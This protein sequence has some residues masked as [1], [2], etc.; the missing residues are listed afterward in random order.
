MSSPSL[1][2]KARRLVLGRHRWVSHW[3]ELTLKGHLCPFSSC[4]LVWTSISTNIHVTISFSCRLTSNKR[5]QRINKNTLLESVGDME[6]TIRGIIHLLTF[7]AS[8][9][10]ASFISVK[11]IINI[12]TCICAYIP[13]LPIQRANFQIFS[14]ASHWR[15]LF[16]I[17]TSRIWGSKG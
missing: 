10:Y 3:M 8:V 13:H 6:F 12:W 1:Q 15:G 14:N 16:I 5:V 4:L 17:V 11:F 7:L 9:C 2:P